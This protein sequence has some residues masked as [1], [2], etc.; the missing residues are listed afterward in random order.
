MITE[1]QKQ[2]QFW[3]RDHTEQ[4][5]FSVSRLFKAFAALIA[6]FSVVLQGTSLLSLG[7]WWDMTCFWSV[8]FNS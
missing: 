2:N 5:L 7:T 8:I 4:S 6:I 3:N 1:K